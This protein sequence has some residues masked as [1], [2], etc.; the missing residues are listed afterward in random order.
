MDDFPLVAMLIFLQCD[1]DLGGFLVP[2]SCVE[3][4]IFCSSD[5]LPDIQLELDNRNS[6][7]SIWVGSEI[8]IEDVGPRTYWTQHIPLRDGFPLLYGMFNMLQ[9]CFM[10]CSVYPCAVVLL[11]KV[12]G[13]NIDLPYAF[14]FALFKNLG[15]FDALTLHKN[16]DSQDI[17]F[18]AVPNILVIL[19]ISG[20]PCSSMNSLTYLDEVK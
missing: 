12:N 19:I 15:F 18:S 1:S 5:I 13:L 4:F 3:W 17:H 7:R 11:G 16:L 20:S 10:R 9:V 6:S 14:A 2:V 8:F